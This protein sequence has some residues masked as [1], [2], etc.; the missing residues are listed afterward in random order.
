MSC[1]FSWYRMNKTNMSMD[2]GTY[3]ARYVHKTRI[4]VYVI[5]C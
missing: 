1:G 2:L 4:K 5:M 3:T